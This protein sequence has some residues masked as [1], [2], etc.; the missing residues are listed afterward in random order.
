MNLSPLGL[1]A[2]KV[3]AAVPARRADVSASE[4]LSVLSVLSSL[5]QPASAISPTRAR[6]M[7]GILRSRM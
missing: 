7:S 5:P 1:T 2:A 4:L 3:P 6:T